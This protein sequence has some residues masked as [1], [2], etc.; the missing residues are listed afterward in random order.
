M[1]GLSVQTASFRSV[2]ILL[3]DKGQHSKL[4][5]KAVLTF[6]LY[7]RDKLLDHQL[8]LLVKLRVKEVYLLQVFLTTTS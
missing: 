4:R 3:E 6:M 5:Q 7:L 1:D 2:S 8:Q